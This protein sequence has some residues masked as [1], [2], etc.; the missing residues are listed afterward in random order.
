MDDTQ[1]RNAMNK[2]E[3]CEKIKNYEK[4]LYAVAF[5][6]LKNEADT[7]DAVCSAIEKSYGSLGQ[8]RSPHKFKP[9]ITTIV[10]NEALQILRKR[11]ELPGN[12]AIETMLE[13]IVDQHNE[14]WDIVAA[15]PEEYR[16]VIV[17]YYYNGLT[18]REISGILEIPIGT[19]KSR[20]NR[21]RNILKEALEDKEVR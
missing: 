19:V 20:M 10:R 8:L 18:I 1:E 13:P 2:A 9:W 21:G 7:E 17:M 12:E 3:F 6:I 15:L 11:M 14:L 4:Q 5:A 16:L